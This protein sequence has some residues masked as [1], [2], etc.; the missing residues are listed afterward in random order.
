MPIEEKRP[1]PEALL[2]R[3]KEEEKSQDKGQLKIFFGA[4]PGV[5]KTYAMLQEAL[6]KLAEGY[7][8]V[9]GVV[10][11]HGRSE[12]AAMLSKFEQIPRQ[13]VMYHERELEEFDLDRAL[14]RKPGLILVDELA[15]T[16]LPSSRHA[17]RWQDVKELLQCGIDVYT[18]LNVQHIESLNDVVAQITGVTVRET[19][20]D[21]I[22]EEAYSV[23]LID[24]PPDDLLKRLERGKVYAP[25]H[26]KI[27]TQRFFNRGNLIALRELALRATAARV[28]EQTLTYREA[29]SIQKS[30]PTTEKLLVC[31]TPEASASKLVRAAKRMATRLQAE[32]FVVYIETN[33]RNELSKIERHHLLNQFRL[34]ESLGAKT[35]T[36]NGRDYVEEL[37]QFARDHNVTKIVMDKYFRQKHK[38]FIFEN[39]ADKLIRNSGDID[40]YLIQ[41]GYDKN[42][43]L[44]PTL[45]LRPTSTWQSYTRGVLIVALCTL[46]S[47]VLSHF[48]FQLS[49]LVMIYL[50]GIVMIAMQGRY[51]PTILASLCS[52]VAFD[53][54]FVSPRLA[55]VI[56][57]TQYLITFFVML[58]VSLV[59][60]QLAIMRR[61]QNEVMRLRE[62]R[63]AALYGLS[64]QLASAR[65]LDNI[66]KISVRHSA[67]F[68]ASHVVVLLPDEQG[69]LVDK[70][71]HGTDY[72]LDEKEFS[73]AQWA[74]NF[75]QIAGFGTQ[76]LPF[77][78]AVYLPLLGESKIVGVLRVLPVDANSI[79]I[80]EQMHLLESFANQIAVAIEAEME[81]ATKK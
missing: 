65:G 43:R 48:H 77:T 37:L 27:A 49:N 54:F 10:E 41:G 71:H 51:G 46:L 60:S 62:R 12:V 44:L 55:L 58:I 68:F 19:V 11:S 32:W 34:A 74:Y 28:N 16:N 39:I 26:A 17:K 81:T 9:A 61:R 8:V 30:W 1:D 18:T 80:Q 69:H 7:D 5:G 20:P 45:H 35:S 57:D 73:V 13:Q 21:A 53:F 70:A 3:I 59:I 29:Q 47:F 63:A 33:H 31:I 14:A 79:M 6:E 42:L 36:L 75:G 67:E 38:H 15:H 52:I 56:E 50:L 64:R 23:E 2:A 78:H 76:T 25:E 40:I 4:A 22:L 66:L 72:A 24:L